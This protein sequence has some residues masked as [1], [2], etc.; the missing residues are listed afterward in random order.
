[1]KDIT[2]QINI[3]T[4]T[5]PNTRVSI[6]RVEQGF[7]TDVMTLLDVKGIGSAELIKM[8]A[9]CIWAGSD[10][11][12]G[13]KDRAAGEQCRSLATTLCF[14]LF[15][16]ISVL[17]RAPQYSHLLAP[18]ALIS[19]WVLHDAERLMGDWGGAPGKSAR[20][21][22][23]ASLVDLLNLTSTSRSG[24]RA[25]TANSSIPDY[26]PLDEDVQLLGFLPLQETHRQSIAPLIQRNMLIGVPA[27][28]DDK[29]ARLIRLGRLENL[30]Q[31]LA[32]FR[33]IIFPF[34]FPPFH[35]FP[36]SPFYHSFFPLSLPPVFLPLPPPPPNFPPFP[37]LPSL[38]SLLSISIP[39]SHFC[40][41]SSSFP[42][43][44]S[45]HSLLPIPN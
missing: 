39:S 21:S 5:L 25:S 27:A 43:P 11:D 42:P 15:E 31:H 34:L 1:M 6:S 13:V 45:L 29:D 38:P 17:A 32:L 19:E 18:L 23:V 3:L 36:L 16:R 9:I 33:C 35:P 30:A 28:A 26:A 40:G 7:F 20:Q 8:A 14:R 2:N 4:D 37:L 22:F 10:R 44:L 12:H 41:L 24:S